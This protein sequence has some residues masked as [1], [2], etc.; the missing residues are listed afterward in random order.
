MYHA[1]GTV[2]DLRCDAGNRHRRDHRGLSMVNAAVR[3]LSIGAILLSVSAAHAGQRFGDAKPAVPPAKTT[4]LTSIRFIG[5]A[6]LPVVEI[7]ADGALPEPVVGVLDGPP[8][9]YLDLRD[10]TVGAAAPP[11]TLGVVAQVRVALHS[12]SPEVTRVVIDLTD[13]RGYTLD[14][15]QRR[16]GLI[17]VSITAAAASPLPSSTRAAGRLSSARESGGRGAPA[18]GVNRYRA[19]V[20]PILE[21]LASVAGVLESIDQRTNVASDRLDLA[22]RTLALVRDELDAVRPTEQTTDVHDTLRS[23]CRFATTAVSQARAA[24][25]HDVPWTASSAAAGSLILLDRARAA[26]QAR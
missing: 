15:S 19:Q 7:S 8:R 4:A 20:M 14:E 6:A 10:V 18:A 25:G 26:L 24:N 13:S 2:S 11:G 9:I 12:L 16:T 22:A 3:G 21:Q 23:A 17:R 1:L 5:D